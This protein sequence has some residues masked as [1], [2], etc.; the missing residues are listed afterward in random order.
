MSDTEPITPQ[1]RDA[2]IAG[3]LAY[4]VKKGQRQVVAATGT[5]VEVVAAAA[6]RGGY[7]PEIRA[8]MRLSE[9]MA[10]YRTPTSKIPRASAPP[11]ITRDQFLAMCVRYNFVCSRVGRALKI[12]PTTVLARLREYGLE[13]RIPRTRKARRTVDEE[14][15]SP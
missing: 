6:R 2:F 9:A 12:S 7:D 1:M 4:A 11:P 10:I 5:D 3:I 15:S 14:S 8:S 13:D